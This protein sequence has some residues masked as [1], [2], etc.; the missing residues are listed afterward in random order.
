LTPSSNVREYTDYHEILE[1]EKLDVV[2][3]ATP[4]DYHTNPVCD[5]SKAGLKVFPVKNL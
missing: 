5:A 2:S 3:V 4:D 1:V